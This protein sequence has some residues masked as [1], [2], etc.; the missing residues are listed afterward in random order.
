MSSHTWYVQHGDGSFTAVFHESLRAFDES[1]LVYD[2]LKPRVGSHQWFIV[3][4]LNR[5][6]MEVC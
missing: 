6:C 2:A 1:F 3:G 5:C 4:H